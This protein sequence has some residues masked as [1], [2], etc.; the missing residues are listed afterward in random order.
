VRLVREGEAR[1]VLPTQKTCSTA[2]PLC[3]I[4]PNAI[5]WAEVPLP[6]PIT[7]HTPG[8]ELFQCLVIHMGAVGERERVKGKEKASGVLSGA[9][10]CR[11]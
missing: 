1:M 10:M 9:F 7:Q 5:S 6:V 2:G 8:P 4:Y 11:V 3:I